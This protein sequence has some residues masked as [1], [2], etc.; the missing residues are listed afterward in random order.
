M[1]KQ[2]VTCRQHLPL[3]EFRQSAVLASGRASLR[4]ECKACKSAKDRQVSRLK[5]QHP[6]PTAVDYRCPCC[7]QTEQQ[8]KSTGKFPDRTVWC[9]DHDHATER[10]RGWI[11][12]DCNRIAGISKDDVSLLRRIADYIEKRG[13][14]NG[15][16]DTST[17]G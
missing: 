4:S 8:I 7:G 2:C 13:Y 1:T 17:Q 3:S 9:L 14:I 6:K 16:N 5:R 12:N 11:C 15:H 10:F